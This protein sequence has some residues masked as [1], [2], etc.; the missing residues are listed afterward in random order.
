MVIITCIALIN[1]S[2]ATLEIDRIILSFHTKIVEKLRL[3]NEIVNRLS[4]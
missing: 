4:K 3:V 1:H 2:E